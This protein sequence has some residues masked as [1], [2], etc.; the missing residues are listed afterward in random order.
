MYSQPSPISESSEPLYNPVFQ[1][2][3]NGL[4]QP[5]ETSYQWN[6][7]EMEDFAD[8]HYEPLVP[9]SCSGVSLQT[10]SEVNTEER[11]PQSP[12]SS[13]SFST[14]EDG[15]HDAEENTEIFQEGNIDPNA[16]QNRRSQK[17]GYTPAWKTT[18]VIL[19]KESSNEKQ[20]FAKLRSQKVRES[21]QTKSRYQPA[22]SKRRLSANHNSS[23]ASYSE[24]SPASK[25][26]KGRLNHNLT[27]KRYRSKLNT[28]FATLLSALPTDLVVDRD[29]CHDGG[30]YSDQRTSKV[31]K[32]EVLI[33]AKEHIA[34][35]E[36]TRKA[37]EKEN[38]NLSNDMKHLKELWDGKRIASRIQQ[39]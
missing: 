14:L 18:S 23:S 19:N 8:D 20:K 10:L 15:Q 11:G 31:S 22:R 21:P 7:F 35:L 3:R 36:K 24:N 6:P 27:E 13:A 12:F 37:L 33:L 1:K 34:A 2:S 4:S 29:L 25:S 5:F 17:I 26:Y 32:A 9:P 28:Q 38:R 39:G 16:C 30:E